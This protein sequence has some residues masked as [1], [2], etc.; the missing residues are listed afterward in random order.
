MAFPFNA[1][2]REA[3]GTDEASITHPVHFY[4]ASKNPVNVNGIGNHNRHAN[5][6]DDKQVNSILLFYTIC[7]F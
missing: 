6:R 2:F 1:S 4:F 7:H 5:A 3:K